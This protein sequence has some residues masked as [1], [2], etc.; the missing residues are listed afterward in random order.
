MRLI[1]SYHATRTSCAGGDM[2]NNKEMLV[3]E[4]LASI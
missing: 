1:S 2:A 4:S 3:K